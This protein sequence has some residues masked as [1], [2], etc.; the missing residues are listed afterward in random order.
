MKTNE[1]FSLARLTAELNVAAGLGAKGEA[2]ISLHD[3]RLILV[4][5][6][7][8][9]AGPGVGG[10]FKFE[11]GYD[12]VTELINLFRREL[13]KNKQ[14]PFISV[15]DKAFTLMS[16]LNA[17][18][19]CGFDVGMVYL[20][21]IDMVMSLYESL[22]ATGKGGPIADTIINYE[23]QEEL[24]QWCVSAIPGALGPLLNTLISPPD[25]FKVTTVDSSVTAEK[26]ERA[27]DES[28][29]HFLQQQAI[30][31]VLG[32]IVDSAQQQNSM[33]NAQR[34][35]EEA[36]MCMNRFGVKP[37]MGGQEYCDN[38]L[39]LDNFMAEGVMRFE[40]RRGDLMRDRYKSHVKL[41]GGSLDRFCQRSQYFGRT[42]IVSGKATYTGPNQ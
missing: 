3:G 37:A 12:A 22:T 4:L 27:Y 21:G 13:Y 36:C 18:A 25:A 30:E 17:L 11:V 31:R 40:K 23:N 24:Q 10:A 35:F 26:N 7:S 19:V 32:W 15:D 6:A 5:K 16:N 9:V 34:Q 42:Y 8:L 20:Q 2:S 28:Q 33:D 38:R 41:L 14:N 29:A 1:W 39:Q